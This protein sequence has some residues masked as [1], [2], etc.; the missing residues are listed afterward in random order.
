LGCCA[1]IAKE[2]VIFLRK[3]KNGNRSLSGVEGEMF[4]SKFIVWFIGSTF[5]IVPSE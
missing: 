3:G 4:F 2:F 1:V 5:S